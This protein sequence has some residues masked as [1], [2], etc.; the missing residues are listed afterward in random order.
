V[1]RLVAV[2][3][4]VRGLDTAMT[5][6]ATMDH[7]VGDL[8]E[9]DTV[10]ERMQGVDVVVHAGAIAHDTGDGSRVMAT[11]VLGT[12]NVLQAAT[13]VGVRRVISFSSV[14]ALGA[15]GG[16]QPTSHLPVDDAYPA[17][18]STP[19]QLSK[20]LGEE[21]CRS[22]SERHGIVTLCLRPV[23]VTNPATYAEPTFGSERFVE[24]WRDEF[25]AYVDVRD[26][27]DAALR[28]LS[29]DGVRHDRFLLAAADTSVDIPTRDLVE[30]H[31]PSIPWPLHGPAA[32]VAD[33]PY[34]TLV[35]CSHARTV[36]GWR[37]THSWRDAA[38]ATLESEARS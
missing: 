8:L 32:W 21:I 16:W 35:D 10:R 27:V 20:H 13:E 24:Q 33:D 2:G 23:W 36:L 30:R 28:C 31:H 37:P 11:N 7:H 4:V 17:H 38:R 34:R 15:V 1:E 18:P 29:L 22:F 25:W 3:H 9:L 26:V 6:D 12:W 5:P 14:N 19:Y